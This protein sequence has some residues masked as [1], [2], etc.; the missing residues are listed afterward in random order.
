MGR[1][2]E[3]GFSLIEVL[4]ATALTTF[5]IIALATAV[6][7]AAHASALADQ[8]IAMRNDALN[9]LSDLRAATA[10]DQ[11]ALTRMIGH[12]TTTTIARPRGAP[13]VVAVHVFLEPQ[14]RA[15]PPVGAM[16]GNGTPTVTENVEVAEVTVSESGQS[17]SVRQALY[18]EAPAPGSS[19]NQELR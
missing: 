4:I 9:I 19:V 7:N 6:A 13:Q 12:R 1:E 18:Q 14:I 17:V 11:T 2:H 10:Y 15:V 8:R 5:V 3:R 16:P